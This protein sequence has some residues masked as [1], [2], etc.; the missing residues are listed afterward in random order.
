MKAIAH[1]ATPT[2]VAESD[3]TNWYANRAGVPFVIGGHPNVKCHA[4]L[5][6]D[7]DGAQTDVAMFTVAAGTKV[8]VTRL[9]VVLD[10]ATTAE[11]NVKVGLATSTLTT[12]N[13]TTAGTGLLLNASGFGFATAVGGCNVINIGDGSGILGIGADGAEIRYTVED[14]SGGNI[15]ISV[16]YYEVSS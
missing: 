16:S 9:T 6:A 10:G 7:S 2:E 8:V 15:S 11:T 3:R 5:I 1:G 12:P 13:T 14:P 4:V